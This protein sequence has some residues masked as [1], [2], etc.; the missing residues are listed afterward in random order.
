MKAI[1]FEISFGVVP[2]FTSST[3]SSGVA[4]EEV[5]LAWKEAAAFVKKQTGIFISAQFSAA[6]VIYPVGLDIISET[7]VSVSGISNPK[8]NE[9]DVYTDTVRLISEAVKIALKQKTAT[10]VISQVESYS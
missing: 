7:V 3:T 8:F 9:N 4:L 1:K 5:I 2:G 10:L 6:Q